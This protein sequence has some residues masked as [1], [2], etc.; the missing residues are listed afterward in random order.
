VTDK[1]K[2]IDN[3][4]RI[5]HGIPANVIAGSNDRGDVACADKQLRAVLRMLENQKEQSVVRADLISK[6]PPPKRPFRG[7]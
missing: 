4:I 1:S 3:F 5:I 6:K 2:I 7:R